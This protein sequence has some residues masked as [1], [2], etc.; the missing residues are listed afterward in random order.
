MRRRAFASWPASRGPAV[1]SRHPS[2]KRGEELAELWEGAGLADIRTGP[3]VATAGYESFDDLWDPLPAGP[4]PAGA[5]TASLDAEGQARL[6][7]RLQA[8]LGVGESPFEL[9]ARAW[10]VRGTKT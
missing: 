4:G 9:T 8:R 2:A 5:F 7:E 6:R 1:S 3:L 10:A